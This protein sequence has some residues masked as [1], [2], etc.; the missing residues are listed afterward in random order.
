VFDVK[1]PKL[2]EYAEHIQA[3]KPINVTLPS[4]VL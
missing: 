4:K 2:T 3:G 1:E